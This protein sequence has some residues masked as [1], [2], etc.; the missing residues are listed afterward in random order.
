MPSVDELC[1]DLS[2]E[3]QD[4]DA[5]VGDLDTQ[6]WDLAT[7]AEGWSI[8][9]QI[10]H[11]TFFDEQA[12]RAVAEPGAFESSLPAILE[13]LEGF[14]SRPL[15][16]GRAMRTE[17]VLGR[18]RR[19]RTEMLGVLAAADPGRRVP[20]Y[21]PPMSLASFVT[22]RL[23][24][25]WAH[26]QDI[27]DALRR[28]REP[29]DRLRHIAFLG[30]RARQN[31]YV[32]NGM[33]MPDEEVRVDLSSPSGERW[34][35]NEQADQSVSGKAS[36]FC[37]VVTQRRH[38]DDTELTMEGPMAKEWMSIAQAFAGP[39]GPGRRPGQFRRSK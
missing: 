35:W 28:E 38:L 25:T 14:I 13:D 3:H 9:D 37:L 5:V 11:L 7:P 19:S 22:A 18:W 23:M 31:S 10:S 21:G 34:I 16:E 30:V 2:A 36:D 32:A 24:E 39:P 1:A 12:R 27:V 8:R 4:L 20:W 17:E 6:A 29:T 26:G 15:D 33:A